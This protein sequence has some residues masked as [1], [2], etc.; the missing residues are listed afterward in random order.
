MYHFEPDERAVMSNPMMKKNPFMSMWLS[1]ANSAAGSARGLWIAELHRQ[2]IAMIGEMTQ[3][4][5]R[6]WSGAWML[7]TSRDNRAKIRR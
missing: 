2:Q 7:P 5:L 4:M 6:F 3:Q 1:G